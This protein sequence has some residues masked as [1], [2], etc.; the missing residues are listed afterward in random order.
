MFFFGVY[1]LLLFLL[2]SYAQ[3]LETLLDFDYCVPLEGILFFLNIC[4]LWPFW[5]CDELCGIST[6]WDKYPLFCQFAINIS[7]LIIYS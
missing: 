5:P 1:L 4:T 3:A 2:L 6:V 7:Q